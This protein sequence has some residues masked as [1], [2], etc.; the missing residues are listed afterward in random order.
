MVQHGHEL[1]VIR[2]H[3]GG[4]LLRPALQVFPQ[5]VQLGMQ[6]VAFAEGDLP[7]VALGV[8]RDDL[9]CRAPVLLPDKMIVG[10]PVDRFF[11]GNV[12]IRMQADMRTLLPQGMEEPAFPFPQCGKTGN[13]DVPRGGRL[14]Q[15]RN[16]RGMGGGF[17]DVK[18]WGGPILFPQ[19]LGI[20]LLNAPQCAEQG[21]GKGGNFVFCI[22]Q[23]A[24]FH[25]VGETFFHQ[26]GKADA[27]RQK[28]RHIHTGQAGVQAVILLRQ[29][30]DTGVQ[31]RHAIQQQ[32]AVQRALRVLGAVFRHQ[33]LQSDHARQQQGARQAGVLLE[34]LQQI[35]A[36]A[37]VR[38]NQNGA[39]QLAVRQLHHVAQQ[40]GQKGGVPR[41]Q[42][43][44]GH[45]CISGRRLCMPQARGEASRGEQ[46]SAVTLRQQRL[47][48]YSSRPC[49]GR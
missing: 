10:G 19:L 20:Q 33:F 35:A 18:T 32:R 31:Q 16:V 27:P 23:I 43:E 49:A 26:A 4:G 8:R 3:N 1:G 37:V 25:A 38:H 28:S 44:G 2:Q 22:V 12:H 48:K 11:I 29:G 46:L 17:P 34:Q 45:A 9:R 6:I 7:R 47:S 40:R 5:A 42:S 14:I 21:G 30:V 13:E 39:A 41:I 24:R 15:R 36:R